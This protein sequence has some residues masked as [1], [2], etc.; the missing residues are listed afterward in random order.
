MTTTLTW[1]DLGLALATQ[2][3]LDQLRTALLRRRKG[4]G[5][6][7]GLAVLFLGADGHDAAALLGQDLKLPVRQVDLSRV[8]SRYLGETEKNLDAL[9]ARAESLD[10]VLLI[11]EGEAL[12]GK[13]TA[14]ADA[15]DRFANQETNY[16]L[17]RIESH[18]GIVVL[19]SNSRPKLDQ[20]FARRLQLIVEFPLPDVEQRWQLWQKALGKNAGDNPKIDLAALAREHVL[21]AGQIASA[22]RQALQAATQ[23]P[24]RKLSLAIILDAIRLEERKPGRRT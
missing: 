4:R 19:T 5:R 6:K 22:A 2:A 16:L 14:I 21:S 24:D 1:A 20:A 15:N 13:R 9:L 18:D 23:Q 11:D 7:P 17:E 3:A 12:F 8:V 10:V